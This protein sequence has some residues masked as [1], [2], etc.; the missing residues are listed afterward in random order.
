MNAGNPEEKAPS[1]A[2][3]VLH[4]YGKAT[5]K[6]FLEPEG[7][8]YFLEPG[9]QCE[10]RVVPPQP[11]PTLTFDDDGTVSVWHESWASIFRDGNEVEDR[12]PTPAELEQWRKQH[13][14][15]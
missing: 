11:P 4:N 15:A 6:F 12:L 9:E 2:A 3:L 7:M 13:P 10:L 8:H 5:V 1:V 14:D